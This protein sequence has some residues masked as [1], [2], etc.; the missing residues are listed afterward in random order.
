MVKDLN[1]LILAFFFRKTLKDKERLEEEKRKFTQNQR[2]GGPIATG[3]KR[4]VSQAFGEFE[5]LPI[6][7]QVKKLKALQEAGKNAHEHL[8]TYVHEKYE[9]RRTDFSDVIEKMRADVATLQNSDTVL[10]EKVTYVNQELEKL[11]SGNTVKEMIR[12]H[13]TKQTKP[14]EKRLKARIDTIE[15]YLDAK[16]KEEVQKSIQEKIDALEKSLQEVS[17]DQEK[18]RD[19]HGYGK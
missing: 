9:Q 4:T 2:Q 14:L 13:V 16:E 12:D 11:V 5:A 18:L 1:L 15:K 3:S 17:L 10:D 7:Q 6:H 8:K 19:K